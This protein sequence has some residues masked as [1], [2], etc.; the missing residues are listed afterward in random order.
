MS[1]IPYRVSHRKTSI[2]GKVPSIESLLTGEFYIQLADEKVFFKNADNSRLVT[3]I[4]DASGNGL[5]KIKFSG[6]QNLDIPYWS[7]NRFY[8]TG[9]SN[10]V[11]S[12]AT[13]AFITTGQTGVFGNGVAANTGE[14]TG[15]FVQKTQTG[16]FITTGQ[17]GAFGNGIATNTGELTGVF[18][19]KTQTGDFLTTGQLSSSSTYST[20]FFAD[21]TKS[22]FFPLRG[23]AGTNTENYIVTIGGLGHGPE[24][25]VLNEI[26]SGISFYE[27]IPSGNIVNVRVINS[28]IS[29]INFSGVTIETGNFVTKDQ[30]GQFATS[31]N[32]GDLTGSFVQY[33]KNW[34]STFLV[35]RNYTPSGSQGYL[36][37]QD[38]NYTT[39]HSLGSL[40]LAMFEACIFGWGN[41][42][43]NEI[44]AAKIE[45]LI[46]YNQVLISTKNIY[47]KNN[48]NDDINVNMN[49][50][51]MTITVSGNSDM[52]WAGR[53]NIIT[54]R[55]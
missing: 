48:Q 54:M 43:N 35:G 19:Q 34:E 11:Q 55:N 32:T 52:Y 13:G 14:L 46:K 25:Y 33:N 23:Y 31:F 49:N 42:V 22:G 10:F 21:G 50:N 26:N 18:V 24:T 47:L 51:Q 40:D 8:S 1:I 4:T 2:T 37:R 3:V 29:G 45:G 36:Q 44:T 5:E 41:V 6:A 12:N 20:S 39:L 17:T 27:N 53:V 9:I 16:A 30:T 7:G 38:N 15:V 28:K